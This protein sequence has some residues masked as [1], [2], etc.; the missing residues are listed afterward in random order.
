MSSSAWLATLA[1]AQ[2]PP[3]HEATYGE[4]AGHSKTISTHTD[5]PGET[6][7][8]LAAYATMEVF[9]DERHVDAMAW[10]PF[11]NEIALGLKDEIHFFSVYTSEYRSLVLSNKDMSAPIKQIQYSPKTPSLIAVVCLQGVVLWKLGKDKDDE[12]GSIATLPCSKDAVLVSFS[13]CAK[14]LAVGFSTGKVLIWTIALIGQKRPGYLSRFLGFGDVDMGPENIEFEVNG[15]VQSLCWSDS[16]SFLAVS[17]LGKHFSVID[18]Q[19]WSKRDWDPS[20]MNGS[21]YV[22]MVCWGPEDMLMVNPKYSSC[23]S[24]VVMPPLVDY[25]RHKGSWGVKGLFMQSSEV[26]DLHKVKIRD[27][28]TGDTSVF[29]GNVKQVAWSPDGKRVAISFADCDLIALFHATFNRRRTVPAFT[30]LTGIRA[31]ATAGAPVAMSFSPSF[32]RGSL[33]AVQWSNNR[34]STYPMIYDSRIPTH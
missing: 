26:M 30:P 17:A 27:E 33:L 23:M 8:S 4:L 32:S 31:P 24:V 9:P 15:S 25:Q 6:N 10:D 18:T 11:R 1:S 34:V 20:G 12:Y 3:V 29:G 14:F 19:K 28:L 7:S 5:A 16:G 13:P 2:V 22:N 21:G